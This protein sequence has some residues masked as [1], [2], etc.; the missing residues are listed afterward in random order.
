MLYTL[1]YTFTFYFISH[2]V[3]VAY[4]IWISHFYFLKCLRILHINVVAQL[5]WIHL[6]NETNQENQIIFL[7]YSIPDNPLPRET[8]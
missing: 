1:F 5:I 3:I 6:P 8:N 2:R 4:H 7:I